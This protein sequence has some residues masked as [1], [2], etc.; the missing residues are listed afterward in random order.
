[1]IKN[2]LQRMV[3]LAAL[4][5]TM[6]C[7]SAC[8]NMDVDTDEGLMNA[9]VKR[10]KLDKA[11]PKITG[12][13]SNP[14]KIAPYIDVLTEMYMK[15][16]A[17]DRD[18]I[19]AL[20]Q[21]GD[22]KADKAFEKA[23]S[24]TD[25]KQ[26]MQAAYGIKKTLNAN[27]QKK[28]LDRWEELKNPEVKRV[29]LDTGTTIK[30]DAI[31]G[32]A[33]ELLSGNF[34]DTPYALLRA[35]CNVLAFQQD[36]STADTLVVALF[37]MD[38]AGHS[39]TTDCTKALLSLGKEKVTPILITAYKLENKDLNKFIDEH[40]DTMTSDTVRNNMANDLAILRAT[41][42]VKPM[43]DVISNTKQIPI[44][45]TLVMKPS[46]DP[47]WTQWASLVGASSQASFFAINDIGV[48]GNE[49]EAK[50]IFTEIFKWT[51][52]YQSKFKNAIK[53]TGT[54]NIEVSQRVNAFRVLRENGLLSSEETLA[55]VEMLKGEE[56]KDEHMFRHY[57]RSS[58]ATDMITY[59]AVTAK[60]GEI[61][62][63]WQ[64]FSDMKAPDGVFY[65]PEEEANNPKSNHANVNISKRIDDV[66]PAFEL[67][68][69]CDA[70]APCYAKA[71]FNADGTVNDSKESNYQRIRAVYEFGSTGEHEYF[72]TI[73][74]LYHTFDMFG[75]IY[76]TNALAKLG[77]KDDIPKIE[78]L[79]KEL[80]KSMNQISYQSAK[81]NL[82]NLIFTLRNK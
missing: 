23:A 32:K 39:L 45:G 41:E 6:G 35:S 80:A 10:E 43:L 62:T 58:I 57:A 11:I 17:F 71:V 79:I 20:A 81:P 38:Q 34:D 74:K 40:P 73:C 33:K 65:L 15:G 26:V 7:F 47:A 12:I 63:I 18:V 70:S 76:A 21:A 67:A 77:T 37:H 2:V 19:T 55:F 59:L 1:M 48:A 50:R 46:G 44:P 28:L 4:F 66:L 53:L 72:D 22:P 56:F 3:M 61:K 8:T 27:I 54:T 24:S 5:I 9:L 42:G 31:A 30:S 25:P 64:A 16:S 36:P 69:T 51:D 60:S 14:E 49:E 52:A 29:I 68:D 78:A 13:M 75:Q 82:E